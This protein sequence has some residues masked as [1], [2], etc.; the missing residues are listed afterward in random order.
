MP[1]RV[2]ERDDVRDGDGH[3]AAAARL[4]RRLLRRLRRRERGHERRHAA[5]LVMRKCPMNI[6]DSLIKFHY[7]LIKFAQIFSICS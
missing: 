5:R 1:D 4:L 6:H 3:A 7:V 2:R